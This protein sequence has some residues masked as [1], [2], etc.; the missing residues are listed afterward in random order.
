MKLIILLL[1][2]LSAALASAAPP[3]YTTLAAQRARWA[4]VLRRALVTPAPERHAALR[5]ILDEAAAQA[6]ALARLD[7]RGARTPEGIV[8]PFSLL[9]VLLEHAAK[10]AAHD[11]TSTLAGREAARARRALRRATQNA[12]PA[13][14]SLAWCRAWGRGIQARLPE[15]RRAIDA[16]RRALP[17]GGRSGSRRGR[18]P[19]GEAYDRAA[20][21]RSI[22]ARCAVP[23]A[24]TNSERLHEP[25]GS[26]PKPRPQAPSF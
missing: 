2:V 15:V 7:P 17:A 10:V 26:A 21:L 18:A 5:S 9:P 22:L 4:G 16:A 14:P 11:P 1:L 13:E 25:Q 19:R 23:T 3:D 6:D 20:T 12:V 8:A 24:G